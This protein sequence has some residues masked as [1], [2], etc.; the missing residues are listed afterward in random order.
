MDAFF[1]DP[2]TQPPPQAQPDPKIQI[3]MM[4]LQAQDKKAQVDAEHQA[5]KLQANATLEQQKFEHQKQLAFIE[6]GMKQKESEHKMAVDTHKAQLDAHVANQKLAIQKQ[7]ADKPNTSVEIG[8]DS[9]KIKTDHNV[10]ALHHITSAVTQ[11][12]A[13]HTQMIQDLAKH[14]TAPKRVV[15]DPKTGRISHV[16]PIL[17]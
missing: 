15:R 8:A 16:E 7:V 5:L 3:E 6:M 9:T 10:E 4:K 2:K 13:Q 14:L 12:Q 11:G 1:T 17:Q